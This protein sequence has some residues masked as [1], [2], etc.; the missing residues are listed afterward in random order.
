M[1]HHFLTARGRFRLYP[2]LGAARR[3]QQDTVGASVLDGR[4]HE[5]FQQ[6][7]EDDLARHCSR[8]L[9]DGR[10]VERLS[11]RMDRVCRTRARGPS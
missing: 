6:S 3:N 1:H 11:R 5:G 10:K 8:H 9:D 4:A 7:F 2:N